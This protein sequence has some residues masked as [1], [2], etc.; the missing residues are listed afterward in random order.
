MKI[1]YGIVFLVLVHTFGIFVIL[2]KSDPIKNFIFGNKVKHPLFDMIIILFEGE[3][4]HLPKRNFSR[5]LLTSFILFFWYNELY[6]KDHYFSFC[7]HRI[8]LK[9]FLQYNK[10]LIMISYSTSRKLLNNQLVNWI[11]TRSMYLNQI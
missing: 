8:A 10:W 11:H 4:V 1:L 5:F 7:S 3:I 9:K 2:V 6:I